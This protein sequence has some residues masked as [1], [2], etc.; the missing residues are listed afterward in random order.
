MRKA[1]GTRRLAPKNNHTT[2]SIKTKTKTTN[3]NPKQIRTEVVGAAAA[4]EEAGGEKWT[5]ERA[6]Q[7]A[8]DGVD[9]AKALEE[10]ARRS[11]LRREMSKRLTDGA[12]KFDANTLLVE[13]PKVLGI[14]QKR[15][16]A[17]VRE[18]VGS[19][20]RMLLVQAVSQ[21]RQK[22]PGDAAVS[23]NNLLSAYRAKPESGGNAG[24]VQWGEREE[25]RDLYGA[26]CAQVCFLGG[27][28]VW[29][30]ADLLVPGLPISARGAVRMR[31]EETYPRR[32]SYIVC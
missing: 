26:Y 28:G 22:R 32:S 1:R 14:E 7:A 16:D 6:L 27:E 25:L 31:G 18:L 4:L 13:L 5:A 29:A 24:A 3:Q 30:G 9:V 10:P 23:L 2:Q 12:A 11:L 15:V 17:L 21:H 19:R 20:K 8:K